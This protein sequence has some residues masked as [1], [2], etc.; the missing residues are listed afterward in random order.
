MLNSVRGAANVAVRMLR[1]DWIQAI[2]S[3]AAL[4]VFGLLSASVVARMLG[5]E[6]RG[7]FAAVLLWGG[8]LF[9]ALGL[10][11]VQGVVFAWSRADNPESKSRVLGA[12]IALAG[13][14]SF[15]AIPVAVII[16]RSS[17]HRIEAFDGISAAT[18][19]LAAMPL[20]LY[21]GIL[22]A[23]LLAEG[24][25]G[26][27]WG[28]RVLNSITYLGL[29]LILWAFGTPTVFGA[30]IAAACGITCSAAWASTRF[31]A[32]LGIRPRWDR[33]HVSA[34]ARYSGMTNLAGLPAQLN[35][36]MDQGLMAILL[37]TAVLGQYAVAYSWSTIVTLLG[38]GFS[39]IL[40]AR[41]SVPNRDTVHP[42][43]E[44]LSRYRR[45]A[46]A[47]TAIG[48]L[49]MTMAPFGISLLF[50]PAYSSA[51]WPAVVLCIANIFLTLSQCLH[52]IIRGLGHPKLG[53]PAEFAGLAVN[54][55]SLVLLLAP[56]G[57][58]GA[59]IASLLGYITTLAVLAFQ[60]DRRYPGH[61]NRQ[62]IPS[63]NDIDQTKREIFAL[64]SRLP[65]INKSETSKGEDSC[66][67]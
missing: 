8:F 53:V 56:L 61:V 67:H 16:N 24:K 40:L 47:V 59:A 43:S 21:A 62:F 1:N 45:V 22:G 65:A 36:R 54:G 9:A 5:P 31:I 35:M 12:S 11:G 38:G 29:L 63:R 48:L 55:L 32:Q 39:S 6:A 49:A 10:P 23:A 3:N 37:P 28:I 66:S 20:T 41:S 60:L 4:G 14:F 58:I 25:T 34:L 46:L 15:L 19:Y 57:A 17:L 2:L 27:F 50:G 26:D 33:K 44:T 7:A 52:E 51:L 18:V 13:G 64:L 42:L 30:T